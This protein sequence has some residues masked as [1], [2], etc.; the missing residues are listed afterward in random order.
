MTRWSD[1]EICRYF[2]CTETCEEEMEPRRMMQTKSVE[3]L[4]C[5]KLRAVRFIKYRYHLLAVYLYLK[6]SH[7]IKLHIIYLA[8]YMSNLQANRSTT[9]IAYKRQPARLVSTGMERR[10]RPSLPSSSLSALIYGIRC[11]C[12]TRQLLWTRHE[13]SASRGSQP[14]GDNDSN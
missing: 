3:A 12:S 8:L 7:C 6:M 14:S 11:H 13:V 5:Y 2:I 9:H 10:L 4:T 1:I